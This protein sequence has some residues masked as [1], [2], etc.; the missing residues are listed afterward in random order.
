V[1]WLERLTP[2]WHRLFTQD[3]PEALHFFH[4]R[5]VT[6]TLRT[7][8]YRLVSMNRLPNQRS[9][10]TGLSRRLATARRKGVFP[11]DCIMDTAREVIGA[12]ADAGN[13]T[14]E[15]NEKAADIEDTVDHFTIDQALDHIDALLPDPMLDVERWCGQAA[16]CEIWIEKAA[17][18]AMV[19][20][21][22]RD[23]GVPVVPIRGYSSLTFLHD[24]AQRLANHLAT[25]DHV[26]LLYIGDFD[27]SGLDI[28]RYLREAFAFFE[29]NDVSLHRIALTQRQI[30][31]YALP[32]NPTK[33]A[34]ARSAEYRAQ[35]GR[36]CWEVDAL[37]AAEPDV[38]REIVRDHVLA[39]WDESHY[40]ALRARSHVLARQLVAERMQGLR[41][42]LE[43]LRDAD[44][45]DRAVT[46][47]LDAKE[48]GASA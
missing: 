15:Y 9:S 20:R 18:A 22:V 44:A 26:Y 42:M 17:L 33:S 2:R 7:V 25:H 38:F 11:M 6:P 13:P 16:V 4:Q 32:P 34:D 14:A 27:P 29:L 23:L 30:Q 10:Y 31:H 41:R 19:T 40:D 36:G 48:E 21:W 24:N 45:V 1:T 37:L 46:R 8:Y 35:Y 43:H 39:I 3:I 12:L 47:R 28:D 5:G